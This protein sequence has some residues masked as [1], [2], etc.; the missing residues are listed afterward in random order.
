M[1]KR[2][3][4]I[5]SYQETMQMTAVK[6][7]P[8]PWKVRGYR[9]NEVSI[10]IDC[11]AWEGK[12]RLGGTVGAAYATGT[13]G[14]DPK[15]QEANAVLMAGAPRLLAALTSAVVAHG[16][17]GDDSR[18]AAWWDEAMAAIAAATA[19]PAVA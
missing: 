12:K 11:D 15:V 5:T 7:T 1:F 10:W 14:D 4:T 8:G 19:E 13:G 2:I 17:F 6:H 18:P 16:P 3:K 9:T